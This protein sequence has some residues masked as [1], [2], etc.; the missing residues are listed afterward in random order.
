MEKLFLTIAYLIIAVLTVSS[1]NRYTDSL[2]SLLEKSSA[3]TNRIKLLLGIAQAYYFSKPDSSLIYSDSA[4]KLSRQLNSL[5]GEIAASNFAGE[6]LRSLSLRRP[7]RR[8]RKVLDL[9]VHI[10]RFPKRA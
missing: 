1:Q 5:K 8:Y 2:H 4:V 7:V 3:D 9:R 6:A 10:P